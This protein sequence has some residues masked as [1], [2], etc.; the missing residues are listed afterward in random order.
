MSGIGTITAAEVFAERVELQPRTT[1][2]TTT[3]EGEGWIRSDVAPKTDQIATFRVDTG[4]STIDV[5]ILQPGTS[6]DGVVEALRVSV[7]GTVGYVP[8]IPENKAAFPA[9]RLQHNG[10]V[11]GW[12]DSRG[13]TAFFDVAITA[14]NAPVDDGQ[15]LTVDY[16]VQNTGGSLA[17]TQD[18]R[19]DVGSTE[20]DRDSDVTVASGASTTGQLSW[21]SASGG[22]YTASV[23]S[24]DDSASTSVSVES[25]IPDSVTSRPADDSTVTDN[26]QSGG[27]EI[28]LSLDRSSIGAVISSQ[29][30]GATRAYLV[31]SGDS[32]IQSTNISGLSAGDAFTFDDVGLASGNTYA[33]YLNAEGGNYDVGFVDE[34]NYPYT[35]DDLDIIGGYVNGYDQDQQPRCVNDIGNSGL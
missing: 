12:H 27:V 9:L 31:D 22:S 6:T 34:V 17:N 8:A 32:V 28:E 29:T 13:E 5:P 10:Q 18:I 26:I 14:T 4:G 19:L 33:I 35:G 7:G 15:T 24:D 23:V 30:V 25:A 1:D 2:P 21:G 3:E 20:R 11:Y 16:S